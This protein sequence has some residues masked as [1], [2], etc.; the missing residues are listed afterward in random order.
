[1]KDLMKRWKLANEVIACITTV[2]IISILPLVFHDYYFDIL[3]TKYYFYCGTVICMAAVMLL[4]TLIILRLNKGTIVMTPKLRKSD[5]A[6]IGFLFSIVLSCIWSDY[7]F[8]AFWGTEGRLMG[9]FLYLI[10]GISFFTL[11]HCL[12]FKRW[13][14]EA[15]LVTGMVVCSIGIMQY[16]LIDPFGFKKDIHASHYTSFISTVGNI[17]TYASYVALIFGMST[18]LFVRERNM[19]RKSWYVFTV[20]LSLFALVTGNSDNAYLTIG[21]IVLFLPLYAFRDMYGLNGWAIHHNISIWRE[22]YP[23]DG[24]VYW[25]FWNMSG[26]WL[27]NHIWEHYLFTKDVDFLKKYYPI[28]KGSATFCSEWLIENSKGELV[29]PVSTSPENAYLMPDDT[30][31]SVCEGSTMDI[32]IIRSLFSN[33]IEASKILQTDRDFRSELIKKRSKLKGYQIGS[34]GQ[35]LEWDKEYKESE[36]QH[37]HVSHLFGVYP[38]CDITDNTPELF[39]AARKSLNDRGNKTTGW[40]MAWKISLWARL[41][42]SSNAYEALSNFVNYIDPHVKADNRGGLYRNLLNA[43]PFQIDGNFGATAGI[44]EMLLQSH[45]GNIH[46]LPA[47]PPTWKEGSIKG[48]KARGGFTIDME[49]KEGKMTVANITSPY[50]QTIEIVYNNQIKKTHFNAGERKKISF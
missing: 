44:A 31:A 17:N 19:A 41:Y 29:T 7:R 48:L 25:F 28:L 34:K 23:S 43:L 42:D 37:R 22:A 45:N 30:P 6:M 32:A 39:K 11:G 47:L 26:P 16:F 3:D 27:C 18:T 4:L 1:M 13:Y 15:F 50:E 38:G 20:I 9:T 8:E 10:C 36:P 2:I 12:K 33:T 14:L 24:F 49:W 21:V 46:L 35:L 40:S 5:W